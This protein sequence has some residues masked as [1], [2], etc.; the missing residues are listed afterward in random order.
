VFAHRDETGKTQMRRRHKKGQQ[1][2]HHHAADGDF[3]RN[4][5]MLKINERRR[6]QS[7]NAERTAPRPPRGTGCPKKSQHSAKTVPVNASTRKVAHG[8]FLFAVGALAP[9]PKPRHQRNVQIPRNGISA[10]RA[11]GG[12]MDNALIPRHPVNANVQETAHHATQRKEAHRPKMKRDLRQDFWIENG[13]GH[14]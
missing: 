9:Q 7:R 10:M 8:N 2:S 13:I 14:P 1:Q 3:V 12:R 4:D 5:E 11:M 6:D